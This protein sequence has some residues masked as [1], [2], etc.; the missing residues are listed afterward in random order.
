MFKRFSIKIDVTFLDLLTLL[1]IGLK[2]GHVIDWSWIWILLPQWGVIVILL[3]KVMAVF[4]GRVIQKMK[5]D[6]EK[7]GLHLPPLFG[8]K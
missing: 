6:K 4:C 7:V 5:A 3:L 2:L 8:P 1:F